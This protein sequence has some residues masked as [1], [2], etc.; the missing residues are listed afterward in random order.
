VGRVLYLRRKSNIEVELGGAMK[1]WIFGAA[2]GVVLS[3]G[4]Y[5][6]S[7]VNIICSMQADWC[8]S[9]K[10]EF[11]KTTGIKVNMS[12]KSSG[13]TYAQIKAES[14]NPKTDLWYGGTGDPHLQAAEENLTVEYRSPKMG[15]LHPWA[16]HQA[17]IAGFKTVG[18]YAGALGYGY[19]PEL[20]AKK[21]LPEPK[22]W[23]DLVKPEYKGE[24]QIANP[25]A[26]GTAYTALATLVQVFGEDKAF[27]LLK[28]MHKNVSQYTK[29]GAAPIKAAARGET[30]I[31][32]SFLHDVVGE[33]VAGFPVNTVSPCEGTGYEIGSMSIIKGARN[34]DAAKAFYEWALTPDAQKLAAPAKQFQL[35]SNKAAPQPKE[36]PRFS[37]VKLINYDTKKYGSS[38]ERKRLLDK[39]EKEV[40][41]L[42]K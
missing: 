34:F 25:N 29:S 8:N 23:A 28:D 32:I 15:E 11:E 24:I 3:S 38:A 20:L 16:T 6:Q 26:S 9:A 35:P 41:S 40:N 42:T 12:L 27:Q 14:A 33:K 36:A 7:Q 2:L 19:N 13:E 39:W 30:V 37:D 31:G 10:A 21:K 22:C 5:A 18:V 1:K 4:A 17:Q